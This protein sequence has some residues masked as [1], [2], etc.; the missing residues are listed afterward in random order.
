MPPPL[1]THQPLNRQHPKLCSL[2]SPR[3]PVMNADSG[4]H[5]YQDCKSA[6]RGPEGALSFCFWNVHS[7]KLLG[8][9]DQVLRRPHVGK[10]YTELGSFQDTKLMVSS[11]LQWLPAPARYNVVVAVPRPVS[12]FTATHGWRAS[13]FLALPLHCHPHQPGM[14]IPAPSLANSYSCLKDEARMNPF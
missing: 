4:S 9:S 6:A 3:G 14:P 2:D 11:L 10:R 13:T 7:N 5:S 8:R 12:M 1:P